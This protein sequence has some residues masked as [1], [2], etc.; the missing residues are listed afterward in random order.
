VR[1]V[2]GG[3][4][5]DPASS[6]KA[7]TYV[8]ASR[9]FTVEDDGIGQ[10]WIGR[11]FLNPPY[12]KVNGESQANLFCTKCMAEYEAHGVEAAIILVNSVHSQNW[13]AP[14]Y[15]Y[16][17]CFVD[18]RIAFMDASGDENPNPTFQNIFIYL[19]PDKQRFAAVFG[20][21]GYVMEK[22]DV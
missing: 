8:Q 17:V 3:I 21:F 15:E 13:Q 6:P 12:G 2:L 16:P 7:N 4:D 11:V 20:E 9:I 10:D 19:G 5:L 14:L 22:I 18:H 1:Q